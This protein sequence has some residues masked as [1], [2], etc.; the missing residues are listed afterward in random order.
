MLLRQMNLSPRTPR[1]GE[2]AGETTEAETGIESS[3][4]MKS[5]PGEHLTSPTKSRNRTSPPVHFPLDSTSAITAFTRWDEKAGLRG[6]R[7][8]PKDRRARG[9]K[10]RRPA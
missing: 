9:A 7:Y 3:E 1:G 6:M 8:A 5:R 4:F 2:L 10:K